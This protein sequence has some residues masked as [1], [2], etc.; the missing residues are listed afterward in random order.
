MLKYSRYPLQENWHGLCEEIGAM[1]NNTITRINTP[2]YAAPV[3]KLDPPRKVWYNR[4]F[5]PSRPA[6]PNQRAYTPLC[7]QLVTQSRD[8]L[9]N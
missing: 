8:L 2:Y 5:R 7:Q 9:S 1:K 3:E 6:Q 4:R